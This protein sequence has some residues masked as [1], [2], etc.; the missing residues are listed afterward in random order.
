[1]RPI[2]LSLFLLS[3]AFS[4]AGVTDFKMQQSDGAT[5]PPIRFT[6]KMRK[7]HQRDLAT[8]LKE[9]Y[10]DFAPADPACKSLLWWFS[11]WTHGQ[12]GEFA[13][14]A[15][16]HDIGVRYFN[17]C[18]D[19]STK[20]AAVKH[21]PDAFKAA[22][23]RR[24]AFELIEMRMFHRTNDE[25]NRLSAIPADSTLIEAKNAVALALAVPRTYGRASLRDPVK[26]KLLYDALASI[27]PGFDPAGYYWI[28]PKFDVP[29][30]Q[31][32][33]P[34]LHFAVPTSG[35]RVKICLYSLD[36]TMPILLP[37]QPWLQKLM[38]TLPAGVDEP[39][40]APQKQTI[41][42]VSMTNM[43][44][45]NARLNL[46]LAFRGN[47]PPN[48]WATV[49][50][51][52]NRPYTVT[53]APQSDSAPPNHHLKAKG[54]V[55]VRGAPQVIELNIK[56]TMTGK[57]VKASYSCTRT[58]GAV[59]TNITGIVTGQALPETP[60]KNSA[61]A[62]SWPWL[63]GPLNSNSSDLHEHKLVDNMQ[64]A[65]LAWV[66]ADTIPCGRGP[67]TRGNAKCLP[68]TPLMGGW[69]SPVMANERVYM[70]YYVPSGTNYAWGADKEVAKPGAVKEH[71]RV[72]LTDAD[73]VLH[74]FDARTGR[75]LWRRRYPGQGLNWAGFNK[76]GPSPTPCIAVKSPARPGPN[77]MCA[78]GS[79]GKVY[80]VNANTGA[81]L[82][83]S[84]IGRRTRL[85]ENHRKYLRGAQAIYGSRDDF[86]SALV[87]A[88]GAVILCDHVS[89]KGGDGHYRYEMSNG[90][91]A[92]D[93]RTGKR[94]W[95]LPEKCNRAIRWNHKDKEY[96]LAAGRSMVMCLEPMTGKVLWEAPGSAGG[97]IALPVMGDHFVCGFEGR[98]AC[99]KITPEGATKLWSG[100][101]AAP[102]VP[103]PLIH[104][105]HVYTGSG[106]IGCIELATGKGV[107]GASQGGWGLMV[108]TG[109]RIILS[110][111]QG[112]VSGALA[113]IQA[114]PPKV[115]K[116]G[117]IWNVPLAGCYSA[118]LQP[119]MA[120]GRMFVRFTDRLVCY[121]LREA[122]AVAKRPHLLSKQQEASAAAAAAKV[123][124]PPKMDEMDDADLDLDL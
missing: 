103:P 82:W 59:S 91:L 12:P 18:Q 108:A 5:P 38:D 124:K 60:P 77:R 84:S 78:L 51:V 116:L 88:G 31:N 112:H 101:G 34:M 44:P 105:G 33:G 55:P 17:Q 102:G 32:S 30:G 11:C 24:Y 73:D 87:P 122:N 92:L 69:G 99:Y 111:D 10:P 70:Y 80:C 29:M 106:G 76:A 25:V 3:A 56:L 117:G 48:A 94:L 120:D 58:S 23:R 50:T 119:V 109:G 36:P 7:D 79:A 93:I 8:Y 107:R 61:V 98:L 118:P 71:Y 90:L 97:A 62:G 46:Y 49:P 115:A 74:C 96:V 13:L 54:T 40:A 19:I 42:H 63:Y 113:W 20:L 64:K 4:H 68:N 85:M 53:L 26:G 47:D 37:P 35:K 100:Q 95:H 41:V 22:W 43:L 67:D 14:S 114:E 75:T 52:N 89:T 27:N 104:R 65:R 81:T 45:E 6:G 57:D 121:D 21:L 66:S 28:S 16:Y 83:Q 1:M 110:L 9:K 15:K 123:L 72:N 86:S 2:V 39:R